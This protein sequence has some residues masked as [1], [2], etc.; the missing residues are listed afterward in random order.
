MDPDRQKLEEMYRLTKDN[1]RMLHS[2][3]RNAFWGGLLK[4]VIYAGL[5]GVP[6]WFYLSY[7]AP[8]LQSMMQTMNQLQGTGTKASAQMSSFQDMMKQAQALFDRFGSSSST[9]R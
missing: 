7:F 3:R 9:V 1:N 6:I 2:M 5:I 8:V 4:F